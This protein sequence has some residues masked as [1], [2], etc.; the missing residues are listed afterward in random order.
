M[1]ADGERLKDLMNGAQKTV[2]LCAPFIKVDALQTVLSVISVDV[3]VRIV[4]RWRATEV[5]A[6]VSDL[7]VFELSNDRPRT[8]I[9][10]LDDLHAKLYMADDSGLAGSA[11]LTGAALGWAQQSNVELLLPVTQS[12]A[13]VSRLLLRLQN[14]EP[15]TYAIRTL[16]KAEAEALNVARLDE[17]LDF[18]DDIDVNPNFA[19][20]PSCAAPDSLRTIYENPHTTVV[21]KGTR[22]DGLADLRDLH[23]PARLTPVEFTIAVQDTL[24]LM[25]AFER[26][27][28]QIPQG[29]TDSAGISLISDL[30][31]DLNQSSAKH[32]W[33][34]VRDWISEF[35]PERF[36]VAPESFITRLKPR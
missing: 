8:K 10:L 12:N 21:V 26:I 2:L 29:L 25:P 34:I 13:D 22:D 24:L 4:T 27:V 11:N 17:G 7:E 23:I 28:G 15:A 18:R 19:W 1:I 16:I 20:L 14:A 33:R 36:E 30:R 3:A 9:S 35:F 6:G 5:A 32:Q 31:P